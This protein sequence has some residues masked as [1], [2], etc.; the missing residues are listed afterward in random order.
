MKYSESFVS[1][2]VDV[3][4]R[5]KGIRADLR[6]ADSDALEWKAWQ[7]IH[8]FLEDLEKDEK[9]RNILVLIAS[10]I[11]SDTNPQNGNKKFGQAIRLIYPPPKEYKQFPLRFARILSCDDIEELL[12]SM[13]PMIRLIASKGIKLDF[14]ALM[15]DLL[16]FLQKEKQSDVK[17]RWMQQYLTGEKEDD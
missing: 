16:W 9:K 8:V 4:K 2:I 12:L 7:Y 5:D 6:R 3:C 17:A 15:D 1:Y 11:A 10:S 13:R 14:A